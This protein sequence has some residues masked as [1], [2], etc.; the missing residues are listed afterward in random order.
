MSMT[1]DRLTGRRYEPIDVRKIEFL[2]RGDPGLFIFS[3][4]GCV[5]HWCRQSKISPANN[6]PKGL[7]FKFNIHRNFQRD[8][9][10]RIYHQWMVNSAPKQFLDQIFL[11]GSDGERT[12]HP[13][14][15]RAIYL[16][17]IAFRDH[18]VEAAR[19]VLDQAIRTNVTETEQSHKAEWYRGLVTDDLREDIYKLWAPI[20]PINDL[21]QSGHQTT[22]DAAHLPD[23][24]QL[25]QDLKAPQQAKFA[26]L[27]QSNHQQFHKFFQH[28]RANHSYI[29][30]PNRLHL[31]SHHSFLPFV[32][33]SKDP[34]TAPADFNRYQDWQSNA[35]WN[36]QHGNLMPN[37]YGP[38]LGPPI[39]TINTP[40]VIKQASSVT[41]PDRRPSLIV[42]LK[43]PQGTMNAAFRAPVANMMSTQQSASAAP[44]T[45]TGFFGSWT[46]SHKIW[47]PGGHGG[48]STPVGQAST[49]TMRNRG[50]YLATCKTRQRWSR[51]IS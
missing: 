30:N 42:R 34:Y 36:A 29:D 45:N 38:A 28:I 11:K 7:K 23:G 8:T 12:V 24:G 50:C 49:G 21:I 39:S 4:A 10:A 2:Y 26:S 19:H 33:G 27:Q 5:Y 47:N 18:G 25:S 20:I 31:A 3:I 13:R 16:A 37:P 32:P 17:R 43:L 22:G 35:T 14:C 41:S 40:Q 1:T 46:M 6:T 15:A 44:A 51:T 48:T 9:Y